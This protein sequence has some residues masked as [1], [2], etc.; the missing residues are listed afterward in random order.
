MFLLN[1]FENRNKLIA[2]FGNG[3]IGSSIMSK[4]NEFCIFSRKFMEFT[5]SDFEKQKRELVRIEQYVSRLVPPQ[6]K[7]IDIIILWSAGK[8]GFT[9]TE[10]EIKSEFETFRNVL[11]MT[12]RFESLYTHIKISFHL[13]SSAGGLFEDQK[14]V[15]P[16]FSPKPVRPYG[17]LKKLQEELLLSSAARIE[18]KIYR[19]SSVYGY[20]KKEH[21]MGLIPTLIFN[22]VR[23]QVTHIYGNLSTLRDYVWCGDLSEYITNIL[24]NDDEENKSS[25]YH[26]VSG[27]PSSIYE[28]QSII[29]KLLGRKIYIAFHNINSN[30]RD[31]TF[32]KTIFPTHWYPKDIETTARLIFFKWRDFGCMPGF[33]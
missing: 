3:L 23:Q 2:V 27:K 22:G 8:A 4:L 28:I 32:S 12:Q 1:D 25:I 11:E 31:I 5:Y 15:A 33:Y 21:R 24:L 19:L 9:A 6:N 20:I 13:I 18:K 16:H 29:E 26:L 17:L 30:N 10:S 7:D 14:C